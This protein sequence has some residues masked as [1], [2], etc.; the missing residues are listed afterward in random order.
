MI[1]TTISHYRIV[2]K[3]G[4]GGMGV[5]YKAEDTRLGRFVALKFLTEDVA[6]D[7]LA[8]ERFRREARAASS[9][10][11]PNICTIYDIGEEGGRA[12][13][14]MEFLEGKTLK[15][16]IGEGKLDLERLLAIG[17]DVADG[18]AA[19]HA[20]GIVHRDIKPG[21]I[22]VTERGLAKILDFGLAKVTAARTAASSDDPTVT[23]SD[24][25][26]HLTSAGG[27]LG[28][29]AYM[30]PEQVRAQPLDA[31][32]DL[33]SFGIVLYQ[34]ATGL[35]PFRGDT[36]A[37]IFDGIMN[38]LPVA[39][40]RLNPDMP[41]RLE[42]IINKA[43]EKDRDL[44]Y[45]NAADIRADLKRLNRDASSN[46][47]GVPGGAS[48]GGRTAAHPRRRWL[49]AA[50]CLLAAGAGAALWT[51]LRPL[52]QPRITGY[53][54]LTHDGISK[55]L[56][57]TDGVRLYFNRFDP[58]SIAQTS[59]SGGEI[60]PVPVALPDPYVLDVSPDGSTFL[61][62]TVIGSPDQPD[63]LWSLPILG[64]TPRRLANATVQATWSP[65]GSSAA[66]STATG[67][68][69]T[70]KSDGSDAR[71]LATVGGQPD[72]LSWSP[73][74][75]RIRFRSSKDNKLW[76]ISSHGTGLRQ[77]LPN[78]HSSE[79][80]CCGRWTADGRYFVF[81]A[82][83]QIWA[84][85]E[86]G[87]PLRRNSEPIQLTTGPLLWAAP[88]VAR[89]GKTIY[90]RGY[91][92]RGELVRLD[93][94]SNSFQPFLS[95][96]SADNVAFSPDGK[97][98]VYVSY[99]DSILW[100]AMPDGSARIQLSP[101]GLHAFAPRW[102]PDSSQIVFSGY[103]GDRS[104]LLSYLVPAEGG[105]PRPLLPG[106]TASQTTADWSPDGH[107][108][109]FGEKRGDSEALRILD[110]A[111]GQTA[112]V[113]G[114]EGASSPRWSPDGRS[115]GAIAAGATG[116][117]L[118]SVATQKWSEVPEKGV[119]YPSWSRDG[120]SIYFLRED[121][122]AGIYRLRIEDGRIERLVDLK[123]YRLTGELDSWMGLDQNDAPMLLRNLDTD[124]I[125]ALA[126]DE[127]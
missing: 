85:D 94:R 20:R 55:T 70:V 108:I 72:W 78:W 4:G 80:Q 112:P 34:M 10:N 97:A 93:P 3:L 2:E 7:A 107:K 106:D 49:I 119:E 33:F 127:N 39:A 9:L 126:L 46:F 118:F 29:I 47:H 44:R 99:P 56:R 116:L 45:Q 53:T 115:I 74:G 86:R 61:L 19:A 1:G 43:L 124:D 35:L 24:V 89:D 57:G 18:L 84:L 103:A 113:P 59:V 100:K 22:F 75:S 12:F 76:Q 8:L 110:L 31:R 41:V 125:Y 96:V 13:I 30:S 60:A 66:Y 91:T 101:P 67:E 37:V 73:D 17:S 15:S 5:V 83:N 102:S 95:G 16:L 58:Y 28:T 81:L 69:W 87:G 68:I 42:E 50:G 32:T 52:S 36:S 62:Q 77:V 63:P 90:A 54:Q 82:N 48:T 14:A 79:E 38:R 117:R 51:M 26:T 98:L 64:G 21:N 71:K 122:D 123:G 92:R 65:D 40:V 121:R 120:R 23:Y 104:P 11:H 109:V 27:A 25:E 105:K 6:G 88:I 114:S 111:S